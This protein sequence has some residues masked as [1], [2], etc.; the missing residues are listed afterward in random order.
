MEEYIG[1]IEDSGGS[2]ASET[3]EKFK[4]ERSNSNK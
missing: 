2:T 1:M 4:G 3:K